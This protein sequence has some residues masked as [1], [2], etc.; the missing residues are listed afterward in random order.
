MF[1]EKL[2]KAE[3]ER[4]TVCLPDVKSIKENVVLDGPFFDNHILRQKLLYIWSKDLKDR[5][6]IA[7]GAHNESAHSKKY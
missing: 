3:S 4:L 7:L 5:T 2:E 6:G 1:P